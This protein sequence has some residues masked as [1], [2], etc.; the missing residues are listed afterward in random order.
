MWLFSYHLW[1]H[2]GITICDLFCGARLL[3]SPLWHH[4]Y[5]ISPVALPSWHRTPDAESE[6][7]HPSPL[8]LHLL[9]TIASTHDRRAL[10][11]AVT[12]RLTQFRHI[13]LVMGDKLRFLDDVADKLP[14]HVC[15]DARDKCQCASSCARCVRPPPTSAREMLIQLRRKLVSL[16]IRQNVADGRLATK[17]DAWLPQRR[18][19]T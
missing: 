14:C 13:H 7:P 19:R 4:S 15:P 1:H 11:R 9:V 12:E 17:S 10:R 16:M 3:I 6:S 18:R 2:L 5:G 8:P